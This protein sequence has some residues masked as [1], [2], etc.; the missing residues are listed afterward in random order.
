MPIEHPIHPDDYPELAVQYYTP[1]EEEDSVEDS[2]SNLE[3]G[4][5]VG[6]SLVG[7]TILTGLGLLEPTQSVEQ[8]NDIAIISNILFD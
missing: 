3:I 7:M 2:V 5:L 6:L 4:L 8:V 1:W